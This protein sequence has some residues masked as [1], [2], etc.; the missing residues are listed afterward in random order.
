MRGEGDACCICTLAEIENDSQPP[1]HS[2]TFGSALQHSTAVN[3]IHHVAYSSDHS[4]IVRSFSID[5]DA[6]KFRV[7]WVYGHA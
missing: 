5:A 3:M 1:A 4:R 6:I 2:G 7:G